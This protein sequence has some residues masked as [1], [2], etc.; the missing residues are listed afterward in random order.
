MPLIPHARK[1]FDWALYKYLHGALKLRRTA[2]YYWCIAN[3][4]R[5]TR[6]FGKF[7]TKP[8]GL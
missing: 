2:C 7:T 1:P 5:A 6:F 3:K 8:T 4:K